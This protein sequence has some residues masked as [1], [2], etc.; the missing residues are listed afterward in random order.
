MASRQHWWLALGAYAHLQG[1]TL[2]IAGL[3]PHQKGKKNAGKQLFDFKKQT[4]WHC[5]T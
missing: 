3:L 4:A 5:T 1:D 2:G